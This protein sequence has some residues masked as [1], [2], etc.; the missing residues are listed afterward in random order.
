[1]NLTT[2]F[3]FLLPALLAAATSAFAAESVTISG[4]HNCCKGCTKSIEKAITSVAGAT[5]AVEKTSVTISAAS[6]ADLQKAADAL[7]AAGYA[8]KSNNS[9][10]KVQPGTAPDEKVAALTISGTH[11]CCGKCVDGVEEAVLAVPGV[12][13]H[14]ATKGADSFKVEG[15]FNAKAVMAALAAAGYSGKA[16]K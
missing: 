13:G 15:D 14:T 3:R 8:G 9:A 7:I 1:M 5:A 4:V 10:V 12:K 11:L 6:I 2:R 16:T